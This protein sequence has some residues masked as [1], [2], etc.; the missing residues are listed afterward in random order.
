MSDP[1]AFLVL[2][3]A[4]LLGRFVTLPSLTAGATRALSWRLFPIVVGAATALFMTWLWGGLDEVAVIH[5]EAAYLLQARL[6]ASGH[7]TAPGLPLP[8]FFEQYHVLVSPRLTPKYF[9]GHALMLVPGIWLGLPGLMP[10]LLLGVCGA[11]VF[12]LAKRLTNPWI[13]LLAW[14]LWMTAPGVMDFE[15]GYLSETTT[16]AFWL[17]GWWALLR[18]IEDERRGWLSII[19]VSIGIGFLTRP[20]TMLIFALPIGAVVLVRVARRRSWSDL[21]IPF[22]IG[23]A[24]LGVWCLWCQRTTGSP[25]LTPWEIYRREYIPDDTFGF[26]LTGQQPLRVLNPDMQVFNERFVQAMHRNYTLASVPSEL[27]H[28]V[29]AIAANMWVTRAML[30]VLALLALFTTSA[31]F[32][33]A[34]GTSVLLVLGY[35]SYAHAAQWSVYYME[36]Q[37]VLA[38]ATAVAWWRLVSLI[39]NRRLAWPLRTVPAVDSGAVFAVLVSALLLVPYLTRMVTYSAVS[40]AEGQEYHRDFRDML[41]LVP[42]DKI[43]VF[44]RY[45][46]NHSPHMALV[47]NAPDLASAKAWTVYDRGKENIKLMSLDPQRTPYLFDDAHGALI[48]LDSTGRMHFDH[49]IREPGTRETQ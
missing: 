21:A 41:A 24:C 12:D 36:I 6:Y 16:G 20:L 10:V 42:G 9:P 27:W 40:K 35:L 7:W 38:F 46:P 29:L 3:L 1:I 44:I 25:L 43:M 5:D 14:F 26:G 22:G 32:W 31:A 2:I 49:L 4:A 47:T 37:P 34:M 18:W 48:P 15:P 33:F 39:A 19:A 11:L 8:E 17:L 13:G 28:R 30:L 45:A 23:F